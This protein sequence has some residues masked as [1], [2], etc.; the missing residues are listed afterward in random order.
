MIHVVSQW[1]LPSAFFYSFQVAPSFHLFYNGPSH[2]IHLYILCFPLN[3][4][5]S[6]FSL[7]LWVS[8]DSTSFFCS[9]CF[10]SSVWR[11]VIFRDSVLLGFPGLSVMSNFQ[12]LVTVSGRYGSTYIAV[13]LARLFSTT[14]YINIFLTSSMLNGSFVVHPKMVPLLNFIL[15][16]SRHF[17]VTSFGHDVRRI[18]FLF[19]FLVL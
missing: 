19:N 9:H 2:C 4:L 3:C 6:S 13:A 10:L 17:S 1:V 11:S 12:P 8:S 15:C 18:F 16:V 7:S 14:Q 5:L